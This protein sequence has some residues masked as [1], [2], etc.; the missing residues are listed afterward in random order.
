MSYRGSQGE[1]N[2]GTMKFTRWNTLFFDRHMARARPAARFFA[3]I[4]E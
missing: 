3:K 2:Y 1:W 4:Q